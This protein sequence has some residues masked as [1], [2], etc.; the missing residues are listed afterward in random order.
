MV[1]IR[2][3]CNLYGSVTSVNHFTIFRF[4]KRLV[5]VKKKLVILQCVICHSRVVVSNLGIFQGFL[6]QIPHKH[7]GS[8]TLE[9]ITVV[10]VC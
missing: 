7:R 1:Q 10:S 4:I 2:L 8:V 9:D 3:L 6:G 5:G